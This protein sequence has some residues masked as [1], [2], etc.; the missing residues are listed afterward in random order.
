MFKFDKEVKWIL[1]QPNFACAGLA[2]GLRR[3]GMEIE[4]KSEAEQAAAIYWMLEMYE[5]H[6][7]KWREAS[8]S[9]M[10]QVW[11]K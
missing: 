1:G 11:H 8:E 3:S 10:R 4:H 7:D 6:G 9:F 2:E 5:L